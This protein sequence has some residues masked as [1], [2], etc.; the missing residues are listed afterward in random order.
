MLPLAFGFGS[1][2]EI[3]MIVGVVVLLFGGSKLAGFGKSL[4]EGIKEFKKATTEEEKAAVVPAVPAAA[5]PEPT[6]TA[7]SRTED[8]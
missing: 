6:V 4:G 7:G 1:P 2:V 5:Y 8:K 3:G